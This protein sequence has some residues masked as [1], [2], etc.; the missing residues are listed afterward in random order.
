MSD[1]KPRYPLN[2]PMDSWCRIPARTPGPMGY[3]DQGDP[4]VTS[5]LGDTPGTLGLLDHGDP[6][7]P[8]Y[9]L[10][11]L[12]SW[13]V[14]ARMSDGVP[15]VLGGDQRA[16]LR[17]VEK[18][19]VKDAKIWGA[20]SPPAGYEVLYEMLT[21]NEGIIPHLY[22]DTKNKVTVG[23]GTYLP[24]VEDAKKLIFYDRQTLAQA[25]AEEIEA[26]YKAV[27]AATPDPKTSPKGKKAESYASVT[28]LEMTPS[29]MG[30][31]WLADVKQFQSLLPSYF[32]GFKKYPV[33]AR[34][35]ITDIAYQYG[36]KGAAVT[37]ANGKLKELA[38][39]GDWTEVAALCSQLEGGA[40]RNAKRKVLFEAA[41]KAA[42]K[43][44][45]VPPPAGAP[46]PGP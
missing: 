1:S 10:Q 13:G 24:S 8:K 23:I 25:T 29:D 44:K 40:N 5:W 31:R 27:V 3:L 28:K 15:L 26:D 7:L 36:A 4:N 43:P 6:S 30:A 34:Q 11:G 18:P 37:A 19:P 39:Q 46:K 2:P 41:A 32:P 20:W 9:D 12:F 45:A 38:E 42:P 35:A 17:E 21:Q 14:C 16:V 33:D 22:L